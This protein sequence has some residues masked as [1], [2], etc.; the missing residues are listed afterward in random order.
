MG[1]VGVRPLLEIIT[2]PSSATAYINN[3]ATFTVGAKLTDNTTASLSYAWYVGVGGA[4]PTLVENKTYTTQNITQETV[5]VIVD[6]TVIDTTTHG[7]A[8]SYGP[9][10]HDVSVPPTGYNVNFSIAGAS[11]GGGS[12]KNGSGG[13][14][15]RGRQDF[16]VPNSQ[17]QGQ[18]FQFRVGSAG[19][20]GGRG[21]FWSHGWCW[22]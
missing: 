4:T 16:T 13:S 22:C 21:Q 12:D 9:G 11:G 19:G 7:F 3:P 10:N 15:G 1:T 5:T 17:A 18:S 2:Q 20:G 14:G 8:Q 6:E